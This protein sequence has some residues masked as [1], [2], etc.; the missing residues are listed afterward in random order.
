MFDR[1]REPA[2]KQLLGK[3]WMHAKQGYAKTDNCTKVL[4]A[5]LPIG[6]AIRT[7]SH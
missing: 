4:S 3:G 5:K 1:I 7:D 6:T 2:K